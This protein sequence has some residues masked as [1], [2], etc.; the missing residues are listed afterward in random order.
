MV[1]A[2]NGHGERAKADPILSYA[3]SKFN[4]CFNT[5]EP[6]MLEEKRKRKEKENQAPAGIEPKSSES[7]RRSNL[8]KT[9]QRWTAQRARAS[10]EGVKLDHFTMKV[11]DTNYVF[12]LIIHTC[13]TLVD[14]HSKLFHQ[15]YAFYALECQQHLFHSCDSCRRVLPCHCGVVD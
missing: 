1:V 2:L 15:C 13:A 11:K 3:F 5:P 7:S 12:I 14:Q 9:V 4:T 10:L 8:T 6:Y